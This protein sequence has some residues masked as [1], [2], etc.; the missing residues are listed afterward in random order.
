[1]AS[2]LWRVVIPSLDIFSHSP[3]MDTSM[4]PMVSVLTVFDCNKV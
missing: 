4:F 3:I 1:M 2:F